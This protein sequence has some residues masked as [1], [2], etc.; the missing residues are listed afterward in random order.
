MAFEL[1]QQFANQAFTVGQQFAFQL[2][3]QK[4][5]LMVSIKEL[6]GIFEETSRFEFFIFLN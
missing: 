6:E 2:Q 1:L 5:T 4:K 3:D